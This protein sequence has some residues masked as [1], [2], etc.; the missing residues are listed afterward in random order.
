M[1]IISTNPGTEIG[2]MTDGNVSYDYFKKV[3]ITPWCRIGPFIIGMITKLILEYYHSTLSVFKIILYTILSIFL[4]GVCIYYPF[5]S[6]SFPRI[7]H[8]LYQS[9]SHQCWALAIGWLIFA[10]STNHGGLVNQILS[11]PIWTIIARLSYSAY[12]IHTILILIQTYNRLSII[13]Y[14]ISVIFNTFISQ[15]IW[16]LLA[17]I[18]VVILVELPCNV[19][20]KHIRKYYKERKEILTNQRNYGT[21]N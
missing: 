3:Y 17:S 1:I 6:S 8:I 14:Q 21:I 18:F 7:L 13:H 2:M 20:E 19:L 16:T 10:C 4:A 11:W 12:L 9:F 5:Y 15:T